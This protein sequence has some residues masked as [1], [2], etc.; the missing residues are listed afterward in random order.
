[1][2]P[3]RPHQVAAQTRVAN[4][5]SSGLLSARRAKQATSVNRETIGGLW[6]K[7]DDELSKTA[8]TGAS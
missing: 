2:Q 4:Q 3:G 8:T 6:S 7:G 5:R 1:V